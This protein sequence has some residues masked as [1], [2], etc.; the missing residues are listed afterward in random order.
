MAKRHIGHRLLAVLGLVAA[1]A[2]SAAAAA[3]APEDRS[4]AFRQCVRD[5]G[6]V[7]AAM[8]ACMAGEYRRLDKALNAAYRG[9][10]R[11]SPGDTARARL[12]DAQRAWLK[13]REA[14]CRAE[15]ER[16]GMAGGTGGLLIEDSCHLRLLSER[17]RWLESQPPTAVQ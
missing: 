16:S 15:V 11:R 12:R 3:P 10:L 2:G 5:S 14:I 17:T 9:A 4:P 7:T 6:G 1:G 13:D 8:R